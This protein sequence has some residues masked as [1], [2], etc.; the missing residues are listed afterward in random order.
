MDTDESR[1]AAL[2]NSKGLRVERFSNVERQQ[3]RTPDFRVFR[4]NQ[5]AFFCEVKTMAPDDIEKQLEKA[6]FVGGA[7]PDPTFNRLTGKIHDAVQQFDAVNSSM[8]YPNVLALVNHDQS[9][10]LNDLYAVL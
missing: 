6:P 3:S 9:V 10:D 5:L 8:E 2:L 1:V 4:G 7:Q